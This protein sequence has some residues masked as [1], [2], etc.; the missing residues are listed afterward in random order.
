MLAATLD[1]FADE[2][3]EQ[4]SLFFDLIDNSSI[5]TLLELLRPSH[6]SLLHYLSIF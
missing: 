5:H 1:S 3:V 2:I 4:G 6:A